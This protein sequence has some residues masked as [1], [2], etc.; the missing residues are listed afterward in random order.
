VAAVAVDASK[1][2]WSVALLTAS[3]LILAGFFA[4]KGSGHPAVGLAFLL[5]IGSSVHVASTSWLMTLGE[6]RQKIR[7]SPYR[8]IVAPAALIATASILAAS[9]STSTMSWLLL[10]YFG[11]QF[12]HF[13]KQNL[14][15]SALSASSSRVPP[16]TKLERQ[17]LTLSGVFAI[18]GLLSRPEVLQT[19]LGYRIGSLFDSAGVLLLATAVLGTC[20]VLRRPLAD[21]SPGFVAVYVMSLLFGAR[22]FLFTSPYAA[23]GG[24]VAAHGLQYLY[25][26]GVLC[27]GGAGGTARIRAVGVLANVALIGGIV[28]SSMSHL[29]SEGPALR[30]LFGAY[31]GVVMSHFVVDAGIW[32]LRDPES[33][34][35]VRNRATFLLPTKGSPPSS[36]VADVSSSGVV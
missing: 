4:P 18:A 35:L 20:N 27:R 13:Q 14:G 10:S 28:L 36:T 24:M 25:L 5:F 23:V 22:I 33:R 21:R 29:H 8:Y 26:L 32:R 15:M 17:T 12:F 31:L 16:L 7:R 2:S 19:N 30:V 6:V 1:F 9:L 34:A 11:W 3:P